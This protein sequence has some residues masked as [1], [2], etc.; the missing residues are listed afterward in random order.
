MILETIVATTDPDGGTRLSPM[1]PHVD[2]RWADHPE[3]TPSMTLRPFAGSSTHD[4]L[5]RHRRAVVHLTDNAD[6]FA[7]GVTGGWTASGVRS[8]TVATEHGPRRMID[9]YRYFVVDVTSVTGDRVRP[10][11]ACDV[12]ASGCPRPPVGPNRGTAAVIEAAIL[13]S[14]LDRLPADEIR[15]GL[16]RLRVAVD[17]TAPPA[18]AAAM[19]RLI[20]YAERRLS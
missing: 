8:A 16:Q 4:N 3:R 12:V 2:D 7:R 11:L 18:T 19:A 5:M 1:G 10:V 15:D 20:R 14:R 6:A 13:V 9:C 17:K